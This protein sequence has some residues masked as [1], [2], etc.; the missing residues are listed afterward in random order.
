MDISVDKSSMYDAVKG[1][2]CRQAKNAGGS[3]A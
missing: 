1:A 3:F 2:T